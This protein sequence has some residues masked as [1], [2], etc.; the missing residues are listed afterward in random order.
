MLLEPL[1]H[2][3]LLLCVLV[4]DPG[5]LGRLGQSALEDLQIS[6]DQLEIDGLDIPGRI[7]TAVHM[8]D[9]VILK[10]ADHMDNGVHFTDIGQELVA[11]SLSSGGTLD[12]TGNVHELD[13]CRGHLFGMKEIAQKFQPLIRYRNDTDIGVDRAEGI[14][15][16]LC[17]CLCQ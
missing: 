8:D 11:Q 5:A 7:H 13:D 12:Q 1:L 15:R 14:I 2:I 17:P 16:H 4:T 3:Q 9:I 10:A 6:K